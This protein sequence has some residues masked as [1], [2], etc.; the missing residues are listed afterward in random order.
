MK[1]NYTSSAG[2]DAEGGSPGKEN[3][4]SAEQEANPN[5]FGFPLSLVKRVMCMDP[6]VLRVSGDGLKAVA[7]A[8]E[9]MLAD[10]AAKAC[11][12]AQGQK[13]KTIKL[14]DIEQTGDM[15][16][17]TPWLGRAH[18]SHNLGLA[19]CISAPGP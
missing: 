8:A 17:Q 18:T 2:G 15:P 1:H 7:K 16:A 6:E 13:R 3:E 5:P 14:S 4:Q 10:M 9:L 19:E 12:A 11:S